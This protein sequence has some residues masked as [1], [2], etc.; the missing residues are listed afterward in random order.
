MN[1]KGLQPIDQKFL[2]VGDL[3]AMEF[4]QGLVFM[5]VMGWEQNKYAPYDGVG[6]VVG[7]SNSGFQRLEDNGKDILYVE[8]TKKKVLHAAIGQSPSYF[9]RYTNYPEG[10]VRLRSIPNLS[11]PTSGDD[12]GY[13]DGDE[14][15]YQRPTDAEELYIPPGVHLDFDFYNADGSEHEPVLNIKLREYNIR[16]LD[17]KDPNDKKAIRRIVQTGSPMPIVP[18]GSMDRQVDYDLIDYWGVRP[19]QFDEARDL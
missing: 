13:I 16:P 9:R 3:F 2:N 15:P 17:P 19:I 11:T 8:K 1:D 14:S 18:A 12:F 7:Q 6:K 10:Q 4:S 5:E